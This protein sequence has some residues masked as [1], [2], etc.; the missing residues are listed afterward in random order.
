MTDAFFLVV[1]IILFVGSWLLM[2]PPG[3]GWWMLFFVCLAVVAG[4][5]EAA[6][7]TVTGLSLS[8][9][10][11]RWS[12]TNHV[13]AWAILACLAVGWGVFLFHLADKLIRMK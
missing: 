3:R 9:H 11:W 2:R 6:L 12:E 10:F 5:F 1:L 7:I 13:A 8:Q 4:I